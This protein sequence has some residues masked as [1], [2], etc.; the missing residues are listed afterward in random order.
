MKS[1]AAGLFE[2]A[3]ACVLKLMRSRSREAAADRNAQVC[4]TGLVYSD[5]Q[6]SVLFALIESLLIIRTD[7]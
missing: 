1:T 2:L 7:L 3:V 4:M 5:F 6:F